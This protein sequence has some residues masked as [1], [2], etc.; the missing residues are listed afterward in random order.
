VDGK[1][2]GNGRGP[3]GDGAQPRGR[4]SVVRLERIRVADGPSTLAS[5]PRKAAIGPDRALVA[6]RRR[7]S[8][9]VAIRDLGFHEEVLDALERD[10]RVD[11]AGAATSLDRAVDVLARVAADVV[12]VCPELAEGLRHPTTRLRLPRVLVVAQ[13]MTVPVLREAI[14]I[15]AHAVYAWPDERGELLDGAAVAPTAQPERGGRRAKVITVLAARGGAGATFLVSNLAAAA[16]DGGAR[17]VILDLDD[18]FGELR[19]ALGLASDRRLRTV[20]D[21]LPVADEL[22]PDHVEDALVAHD[23]GFRA[24]LAAPP[25][26]AGPPPGLYAATA[27]LLAGAHDLV[28]LH[29]P[30]GCEDLRRTAMAL[31]DQTVIVATPDLFALSGVSSLMPRGDVPTERQ[32]CVLVVNRA[33]RRRAR[34]RDFEFVAGIAPSALIRTDRAVPRRQDRGELL[35]RRSR[36]AGRDVRRLVGLLLADGEA[37]GEP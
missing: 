34:A 6:V 19:F 11:V 18:R 12:V 26:A 36:G 30:R 23:R 15:G 7:P 27:A 17:V 8:V 21:L 16:A 31:A 10:S 1:V 3:R 5:D 14:E 9:A 4:G 2:R 24:L 20:A 32:H 35:P 25:G 33:R 28:L 13:E 29:V 37:R 22:T